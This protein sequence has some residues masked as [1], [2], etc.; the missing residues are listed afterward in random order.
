MKQ[1]LR[2]ASNALTFIDL[3]QMIHFCAVQMAEVR[4]VMGSQQP[5]GDAS[6]WRVSQQ[7]VRKPR[8][9]G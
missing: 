4:H 8:R 1:G 6:V 2:T 9:A 7:V 3:T 5:H